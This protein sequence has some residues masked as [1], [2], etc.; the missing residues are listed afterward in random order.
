M[1]MTRQEVLDT[2][3][4]DVEADVDGG[5]D[6][7]ILRRRGT[8]LWVTRGP[9]GGWNISY[10][11]PKHTQF[12]AATNIGQVLDG[13]VELWNV[14]GHWLLQPQHTD[15]LWL[16]CSLRGL[17]PS[18]LKVQRHYLREAI[19]AGARAASILAH[20]EADAPLP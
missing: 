13:K 20:L 16:L 10:S 8:V 3:G 18:V 7:V 1:V 9:R 6:K 17:R 5:A 14:T 19:E 11:L 12:D 4:I 15:L 2:L